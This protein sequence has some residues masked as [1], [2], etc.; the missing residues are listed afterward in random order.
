MSFVTVALPVVS[1]VGI[2]V[3][4]IVELGT[5]RDVVRGPVK[6]SLTL[7]LFILIGTAMFGCCVAEYFFLH[8]S[9]YWPTFLAGWMLAIISFGIRRRAIAALGRFWSLHVEIREHHEFV[10]TG[11][12]RWMRHP[13]YLTMVLELVSGALILNVVYSYAIVF[14]FFLPTLWLRIRLEENALIEKFGDAYRTYQHTTP[15][16]F[17]YKWPRTK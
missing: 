4:R 11:P 10:Q 3:A 8:R 9:L 6:E 12:F 14:F 1:A 2:Y 16:L 5:K 15:A 17:P 13:T 7:R